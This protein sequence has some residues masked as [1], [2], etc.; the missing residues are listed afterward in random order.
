[1]LKVSHRLLFRDYRLQPTRLRTYLPVRTLI[2]AKQR[3]A[4]MRFSPR[5]SEVS[6]VGMPAKQDWYFTGAKTSLYQQG[7]TLSGTLTLSDHCGF[8]RLP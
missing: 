6:V 7:R 1:M 3:K 8:H 2:S 5:L 4:L